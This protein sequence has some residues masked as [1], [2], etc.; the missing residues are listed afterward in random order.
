MSIQFIEGGVT[1][2][3]GFKAASTAAGIKEGR[4]GHGDGL[5]RGGPRARRYIYHQPGAG[6]SS[7]VGQEPGVRRRRPPEPSSSTQALPTPAP[8]RR[9]WTTAATQQGLRG[10]SGRAG[11]QSVLVA[12]TGVIGRAA[13]HGSIEGELSHGPEA[14]RP[15]EDGA[16]RPRPS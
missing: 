16:R 8:A 6:R 14:G 5:Q 9:A 13:A 11:G 12:S 10:G 1:A 4:P 7:E 2:A 15:R 3:K